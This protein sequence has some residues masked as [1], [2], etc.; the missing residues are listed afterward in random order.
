MMFKRYI[1]SVALALSLLQGNAQEVFVANSMSERESAPLAL[2]LH[3]NGLYWLA[4]VP[5]V[6][7]EIQTDWGISLLVDYMGAW[8]NK[9][10]SDR[11][12]SCYGFQTEVRYYPDALENYAPYRGHH[13][14]I[15]GQL[16]TY[17]FEFGG[18]GYQS[19]R[20]GRT[21]GIGLSYGYLL[22]ISRKWSLDFS[23]GIGYLRSGYDKYVPNVWGNY[24]KVS[25]GTWTWIG[26]TS[27]SVSFVWNINNENGK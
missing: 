16:L 18:T 24:S 20:F 11:F 1:L 7:A 6:G 17:D 10:S 23:I 15:Y 4:A 2:S 3:T 8:W 5:N 13:F 12:Y 21:W 27:L 19:A 22:P 25:D 26:P 9:R 14:G